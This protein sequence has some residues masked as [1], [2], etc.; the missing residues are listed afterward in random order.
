MAP[1]KP[2]QPSPLFLSTCYFGASFACLIRRACRKAKELRA[3]FLNWADFRMRRRKFTHL[4]KFQKVR[5]VD[6]PKRTKLMPGKRTQRAIIFRAESPSRDIGIHL[7]L[8]HI[9]LNRFNAGSN[10]F[11]Q[12]FILLSLITLCNR[13][14][15]NSRAKLR[16]SRASWISLLYSLGNSRALCTGLHYRTSDRPALLSDR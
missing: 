7:S 11:F 1:L 2:A 15:P 16:P 6:P 9:A 3:P 10:L 14:L 13:R 8:A 5:F 12:S 4:A